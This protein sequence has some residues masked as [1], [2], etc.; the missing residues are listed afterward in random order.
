MLKITNGKIIIGDEVI[1]SNLYI[2]GGKIAE[3]TDADKPCDRVIDA[4]GSFVSPGF[5]DTHVHG[6]GNAD[7]MDGEPDALRTA[8]KR[9]LSG[10]PPPYA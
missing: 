5:I 9:I 10:E 1:S 4:G 2:D 6:G 8:A 3:I 7:V